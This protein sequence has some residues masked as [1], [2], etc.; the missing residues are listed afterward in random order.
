MGSSS[1]NSPGAGVKTTDSSRGGQCFAASLASVD[2]INLLLPQYCNSCQLKFP[3]KALKAARLSTKMN[4]NSTFGRCNATLLNCSNTT[5]DEDEFDEEESY[6]FYAETDV[7]LIVLAFFIVLVNSLV[8]G[9][10]A[11][12]RNLRMVAG[13]FILVSL[14]CSDILTGLVDIP[15]FL[16]CNIL[17]EETVCY[18][19]NLMLRFTSVSTVLHL[20]VATLDRYLSIMHALRYH[21][22]VTKRRV[23]TSIAAIWL[24]AALMS[25]IQ[26]AWL[27]PQ[28]MG[29]VENPSPE[30]KAIEIRY[31]IFCLVVF[32]A[33]PFSF[34][35]FTYTCIVIAVVRQTRSIERNSVTGWQEPR[36]RTR[37]EWKA[38]TIFVVMLLLFVVCWLPYFILRLQHNIGS[39]LFALP[40]VLEYV[41]TYLRFTT[42]LLNPCLYVFGKRDFRKSLCKT[43]KREPS[44][45]SYSDVTHRSTTV[46]VSKM[47]LCTKRSRTMLFFLC[48]GKSIP[49]IMTLQ[50]PNTQIN[51]GE[52]LQDVTMH[53][54][55]SNNAFLP[56]FRKIYTSHHD[57]TVT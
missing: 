17:V 40:L 10:F 46:K 43:P 33:I 50:W 34:M 52:S 22:L 41:L 23:Y 31:D 21:S 53:L 39:Q 24:A 18:A 37:R 1:F 38:T 6:G 35:A 49:P 7:Y 16:A 29:L 51:H 8:V 11:Q 26:A 54:A 13:N 25:L 45:T 20:L 19:E 47:W 12:R 48:F 5:T 2:P 9:K 57:L 56:L 4:A 36:T 15:L 30:I 3:L 44:N 27:T 42:S 55:K 14:A 32:M 28:N